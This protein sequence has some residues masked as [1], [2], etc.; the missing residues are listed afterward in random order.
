MLGLAQRTAA[1]ARAAPGRADEIA[2]AHQRLT[3]DDEMGQLFQALALSAPRWPQP[4]GF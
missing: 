2:A 1:L 4:A 3:A